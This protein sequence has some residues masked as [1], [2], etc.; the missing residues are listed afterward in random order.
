MSTAAKHRDW[1]MSEARRV[2]RKFDEYLNVG[3]VLTNERPVAYHVRQ[4]RRFNREA[5]M[6]ARITRAWHGDK[7]AADAPRLMYAYAVSA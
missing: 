3:F 4:A 7:R 5:F 6:D 1:H 2:A